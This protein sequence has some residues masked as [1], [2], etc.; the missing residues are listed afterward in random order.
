MSRKLR[1][2]PGKPSQSG[3]I[4]YMKAWHENI[5]YT[6]SKCIVGGIEKFLLWSGK[7][8]LHGKF[9]VRL[10]ALNHAETLL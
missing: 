8:T 10:E 7:D 1:W 2:V 3:V 9:D 5:E 4:Y 6:I